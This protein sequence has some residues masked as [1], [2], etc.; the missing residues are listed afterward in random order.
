[1]SQDMKNNTELFETMSVPRA[2][3]TMAIPTVLGQL[4][5][6]IYNMA[7]T[8][9]IGRT[10][11][12]AMVAAAS[13]VLPVF[14]ITLSLA[15]LAGV[16]GGALVSRLLGQGRPDEA[17]RVYSF[18]VWLSVAMSAVFSLGVLIFM[19]P[20]MRLLGADADTVGYASDYALWVIVIGSIPTVLSGT[21]SGSPAR[22]ASV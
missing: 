12:P 8:F 18:S 7:D 13:L 22:R 5:I 16:G 21:L 20:L 17:R 2:V 11:N 9:F 6:L 1:M 15:G 10:D 19:N 14:N 3:R 4:I